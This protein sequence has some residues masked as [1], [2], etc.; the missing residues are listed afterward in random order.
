MFSDHTYD[1]SKNEDD[2]LRDSYR[3]IHINHG[4][5]L[6]RSINA[7]KSLIGQNSGIRYK[8][9]TRFLAIKLLENDH[10]IEKLTNTLSNADTI[11]TTC[12][13]EKQRLAGGAGEDSEQAITDAKYGFITGA[14]RENLRKQ[15]SRQRADNA[16][17]RCH[18]HPQGLGIP[19][20]LPIHVHHV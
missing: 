2:H 15:P 12:A 20:F 18:R 8:Y 11:K 9:S 13:K 5:E 3:H 4:P 7:I 14:L 19:H 17:N 6:E 16:P 10:E 1:D